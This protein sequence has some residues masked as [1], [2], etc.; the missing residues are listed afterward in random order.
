MTTVDDEKYEHD[1]KISSIN[2][3]DPVSV[4]QYYFETNDKNQD[5]VRFTNMAL[6]IEF[7]KRGIYTANCVPSNSGYI[8]KVV[9]VEAENGFQEIRDLME[10]FI[11]ELPTKLTQIEFSNFTNQDERYRKALEET[12]IFYENS[13]SNSSK[14]WIQVNK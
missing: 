10:K 11:M 12:I 5:F 6:R 14:I 4:T 13:V 9:S 8:I 1:L 3:D 7:Y 2:G